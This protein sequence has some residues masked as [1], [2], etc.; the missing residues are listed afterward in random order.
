MADDGGYP[1]RC[2][3]GLATRWAGLGAE[4]VDRSTAAAAFT[5]ED[6]DKR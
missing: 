5:E 2:D 1:E 4:Y 3:K 6:A